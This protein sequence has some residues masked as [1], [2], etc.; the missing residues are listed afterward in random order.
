MLPRKYSIPRFANP[1]RMWS[2]GATAGLAGGAVEISWIAI[3]QN[4]SGGNA[5]TVAAGVTQSLFPELATTAAAVPLGIAIHLGLAIL[6]GIALA[7]F[8]H[9]LLPRSAPAVLEPVAVIGLLIG[10]WVINFF[11]ILPVI[12]PA[13][14]TL[15]PYA[16]SLT[17]KLLFGVAAALALK[18]FDGPLPF[19]GQE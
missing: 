6:L 10:I 1:T 8:V 7:V 2:A 19:A 14:V 9:S 16:A 3:Y 17:S 5:A 11:L 18:L 15:V 4:L 12:N 13:F